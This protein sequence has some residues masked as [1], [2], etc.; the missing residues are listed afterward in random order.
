LHK[1]LLPC[2]DRGEPVRYGLVPA[3]P[4]ELAQGRRVDGRLEGV[5][6][7]G[8]A[9]RIGDPGIAVA[10]VEEGI[11]E[12]GDPPVGGIEPVTLAIRRGGAIPR[13]GGFMRMAPVEP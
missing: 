11:T 6:A 7:Q 1:V 8:D 13:I 2:P 3:G 4:A 10:A 9:T 5:V 12:I